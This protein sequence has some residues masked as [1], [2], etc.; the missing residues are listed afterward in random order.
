MISPYLMGAVYFLFPELPLFNR[1]F[2]TSDFSFWFLHPLFRRFFSLWRV[3]F[4]D[5]DLQFFSARIQTTIL[6]VS[7][8]DRAFRRWKEFTLSQGKLPRLPTAAWEA[9]S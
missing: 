2:V 9:N 8:Y 5:P 3:V 1:C 4:R 7:M 6:S